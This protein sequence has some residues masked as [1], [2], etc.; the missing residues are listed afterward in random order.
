VSRIGHFAM[1]VAGCLALSTPPKAA[2]QTLE[3]FLANGYSVQRAI[4]PLYTESRDLY[5]K[6]HVEKT[7]VEYQRK[8]FF[9]IGALPIEVLDG[10]EIEIPN[11]EGL[12][13]SLA[14]IQHW[15]KAGARAVALRHARIDVTG[16]ATPR[17]AADRV[18]ISDNHWI[19]SGQVH[20][21]AGTNETRCAQATLWLAG[22]RL[23]QIESP[24][25]LLALAP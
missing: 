4:I 14:R 9:S 1:F 20:I 18:E 6:I 12:T 7:S 25:A 24:T 10:V 11:A 8:G 13:N 16:E 3:K 23:G 17:L 19:V 5:A 22:P 2:A 21:C 15:L